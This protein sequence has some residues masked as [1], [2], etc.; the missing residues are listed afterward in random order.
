MTH[1]KWYQFPNQELADKSEQWQPRTE[2]E[3]FQ[4]KGPETRLELVR[5]D[6]MTFQIAGYQCQEV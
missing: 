1:S 6:V 4:I 3:L 5:G 2:Y